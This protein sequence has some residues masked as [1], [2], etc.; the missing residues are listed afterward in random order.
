MSPRQLSA[1]ATV[2]ARVNS[3]TDDGGRAPAPAPQ[4]RQGTAGDWLAFASLPRR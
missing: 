3:T 1:I 2:H 4:Q